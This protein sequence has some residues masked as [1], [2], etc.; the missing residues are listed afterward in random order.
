[1]GCGCFLGDGH[2]AILW[3]CLC[4]AGLIIRIGSWRRRTPRPT[5]MR[6]RSTGSVFS[7]MFRHLG[8]MPRPFPRA[9]AISRIN[10][11]PSSNS[12]T[13]RRNASTSSPS[14]SPLRTNGAKAGLPFC[15]AFPF[16]GRNVAMPPSRHA[17][18]RSFTASTLAPGCLA[19]CLCYM[20]PSTSSM[21]LRRVL[22]GMAGFLIR[23]A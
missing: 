7:R 17:L 10:V 11:F 8:S 9:S 18:T 16:R 1:M 15:A 5:R 21:A 4:C 6:R 12:A 14:E 3:L 23:P 13:P 22:S 2:A 20:P 19:A